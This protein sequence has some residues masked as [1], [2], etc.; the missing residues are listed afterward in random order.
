VNTRFY[1]RS[2]TALLKNLPE[3]CYL[4]GPGWRRATL[5]TGITSGPFDRTI[6]IHQEK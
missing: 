5:V 4:L 3:K 1:V 6:A 2:V